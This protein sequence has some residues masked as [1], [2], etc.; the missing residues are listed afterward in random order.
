M[1]KIFWYFLLIFIM[2]VIIS[3]IILTEKNKNIE[4]KKTENEI[5]K[6]LSLLNNIDKKIDYFNYKYLDRYINFKNNNS[7]LDDIDIITRV[8]I[9]L[10]NPFYQNI[11]KSNKL[12]DINILVNKYIYLPN[13]Y[14]P[15]NLTTISSKFSNSNKQLV[16]EAKESF[17][18]MATD[19]LEQ[20]YTIRA[21]SAYRSYD[22]QKGL[23]DSYVKKDGIELADS[24]SARPGFSEHQTGLVVDI[25]NGEVDFNNFENTQ[26]FDWMT[27]NSHLYGFIL[28]YPK[29]KE[30]ITGY[31]Y[32]SWHYRY[33]GQKVATFIKEN[34]LT[35]DEYYV[36]YIDK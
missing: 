29:D 31:S 33:V 34:N 23:Y 8:N 32:E 30:M 7:N 18:R 36:R 24:Y 6:K 13:D 2:V 12:N 20:G 35:L 27:N 28:R 22:Y 25:D 3:L 21:I 15:N 14:V 26:E 4:V 17:E 1:K 10:D 19:A 9:G 16:F 5:D 11:K